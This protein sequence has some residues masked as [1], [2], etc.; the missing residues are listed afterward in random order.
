MHRVRTLDGLRGVAALV[1]LFD[2]VCQTVPRLAAPYLHPYPVRV[3]DRAWWFTYTPL[4]LFWDGSQAVFVFF[5]LSGFVLSLPFVRAERLGWRGYFPQRLLRLYLP[6]WAALLVAATEL[7]L[8][9]HQQTPGASWWTRAHVVRPS[10]HLVIHDAML[11]RGTS[12]INDPLW[13]LKW[14]VLFSLTLPL[15]VLVINLGRRRVA[16]TATGLLLS[17]AAG[18]YWRINVLMFLP[19]FG[20]GV[21]M[22]AERER[23]NRLGELLRSRARRG[24]L[25]VACLL[26]LNAY[27]TVYAPGIR[28]AHLQKVV[29]VAQALT[30]AGAGM[31]IFLLLSWPAAGRLGEA[32]V[33]Q[34]LGRRSF[35]LYLVHA[36]LVVCVALLL[37]G[38]AGLLPMMV[39][40]VPLSLAAAEAFYRLVEAP[41][42]R[43]SRHVGRVFLATARPA[44]A[45]R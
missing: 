31:A 22:A 38:H 12:W 33:A 20:L 24:V 6:V 27:W 30:V 17:V 37:G 18:A 29:A 16:V 39:I 15:Y 19:M 26:L 40:C 7:Q 8:V 13:S 5:V 42:H 10:A 45:T 9:H 43:L 32:W 36:P 35:S 41:A 2:H 23:L 44:Y 14:E 11:L 34:W 4:H 25:T 1:V 21:L 28:F 3:G